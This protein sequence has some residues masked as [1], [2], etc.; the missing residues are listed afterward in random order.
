M[1]YGYNSNCDDS[2]IAYPCSTCPPKENGRV[3]GFAL[4]PSTTTF[5]DFT[6]SAEWTNKIATGDVFVVPN[7]AGTV[8]VTPSE[9]PGMGDTEVE[10][11]GYDYVLDLMDRNLDAYDEVLTVLGN[12]SMRIAWITSSK[13]WVSTSTVSAAAF[14][15]I[16]D[17]IKSE[18]RINWQVK[19]YQSSPA[20]TYTRPENVFNTCPTV[21]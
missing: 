19:F 4:I 11:S 14:S 2:L 18:V 21:V 5:S 17:D 12:K 10:I 7:T 6:S 3:R 1:A 15:T 8:A 20:T 16:E 9:T 13:L